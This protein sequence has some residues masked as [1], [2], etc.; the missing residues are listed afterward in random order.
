VLLLKY[1]RRC[2]KNIHLGQMASIQTAAFLVF[3][4]LS[5]H[6]AVPHKKP[7]SESFE[8]NQRVKLWQQ[9]NL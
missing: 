3:F 5:L 7:V 8:N 1:T 2:N 6:L 9:Q 4:F